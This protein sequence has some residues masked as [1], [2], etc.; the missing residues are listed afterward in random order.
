MMMVYSS[1]MSEKGAI[2]F[3]KRLVYHSSP[4]SQRTANLETNAAA[5]GMPRKTATLVAMVEYEGVIWLEE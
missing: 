4:A 5:S 1:P 3:K 2:H